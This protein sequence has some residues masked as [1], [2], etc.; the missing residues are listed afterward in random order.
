MKN[1]SLLFKL[2]SFLT[3]QVSTVWF[4]YSYISSVSTDESVSYSLPKQVSSS[5]LCSF[6]HS[7]HPRKLVN[8]IFKPLHSY[9]PVMQL[10][11]LQLHEP[12]SKIESGAGLLFV[13]CTYPIHH[14]YESNHVELVRII[15]AVRSE[16]IYIPEFDSSPYLKEVCEVLEI[17]NHQ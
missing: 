8:H 2:S 4:G 11:L 5:L 12:N 17:L 1:N 9:T 3:F 7:T 15:V 13:Q 6:S 14:S 16:Q 10:L